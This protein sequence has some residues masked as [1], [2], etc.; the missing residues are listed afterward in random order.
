MPRWGLDFVAVNDVLDCVQVTVG[1]NETN[2]ASKKALTNQPLVQELILLGSGCQSV[3]KNFLDGGLSLG[4]Y[5]KFFH[6]KTTYILPH[7]DKGFSSQGNSNVLHLLGLH[8]V[9]QNNE[10]LFILIEEHM[11][12]LEVFNFFGRE[13]PLKNE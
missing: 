3:Q 6:H 13:L 9:S 12:S 7:H 11:S 1:E 10:D 5:L 4:N 8:I 2:I